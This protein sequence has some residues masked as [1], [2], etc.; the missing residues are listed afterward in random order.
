MKIGHQFPGPAFAQALGYG[1]FESLPDFGAGYAAYILGSK[2]NDTP[3]ANIFAGLA[4]AAGD[5]VIVGSPGDVGLTSSG[6]T[7]TATINNGAMTV[8][9]ITGGAIAVGSLVQGGS[10]LWVVTALGTGTGGTGTYTVSGSNNVS[11][12]S[13]Q[14]TGNRLDIPGI[15]RAIFTATN[16]VTLVAVAKAPATQG[17]LSDFGAPDGGTGSMSLLTPNG[18][19]GAQAFGRD[20]AN[21]QASC[22]I[23]G[24]DANNAAVWS[25]FVGTYTLT[26]AAA[27]I[28]RTASGRLTGPASSK[29]SGAVGNPNHPLR[30][31]RPFNAVPAS[32]A[33]ILA[34][35]TK[36]LSGAEMDQLFSKCVEIMADA[37]ETL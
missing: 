34:A 8:S 37:G 12:L 11:N 29:A 31:G 36:V 26:S 6:A 20:D 1:K 35:Y 9:A 32:R 3:T 7:I 30:F 13:L 15:S 2:L 28:Q 27:Y 10:Y 4:G 24:P 16:A 21:V 18:G 25:M 22:I 33:A 23:S 17:L 19:G 14:V 5:A